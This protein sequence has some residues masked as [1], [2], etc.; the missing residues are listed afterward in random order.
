MPPSASKASEDLAIVRLPPR[1]P[2]CQP[3]QD[4]YDQ[5]HHDGQG[6][7]ERPI[8]GFQKL[9]AYDV[10]DHDSFGSSHQV[11]DREH[12]ESRNEYQ[13]RTGINR[14]EEHTS[15]LQSRENL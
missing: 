11:R 5:R 7:A 15:E 14:S 10:A 3:G 9:G 8:P 1:Q 12:A 13:R 2:G 6:A 4:Q